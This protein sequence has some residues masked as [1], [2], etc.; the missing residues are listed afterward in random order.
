MVNDISNNVD[1]NALKVLLD[2]IVDNVTA[3]ATKLDADT[4][5]ADTDYTGEITISK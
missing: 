1:D 2:E 5:V 4:G 3:I